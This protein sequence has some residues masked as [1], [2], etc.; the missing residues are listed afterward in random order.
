MGAA[1]I[2]KFGFSLGHQQRRLI[3][4]DRRRYPGIEPLPCDLQPFASRFDRTFRKRDPVFGSAD[5]DISRRHLRDQRQTKRAFSLDGA[6]IARPRCIGK[7]AQPAPEIHLVG[8]NRNPDIEAVVGRGVLAARVVLAAAQ[9]RKRRARAHRRRCPGHLWQ[10]LAVLDPVARP[11][12]CDPGHRLGEIAVVGQRRGDIGPQPGI[13]KKILPAKLSSE[14][15][16]G[17]GGRP[18]LRP[19]RRDRRHW[20]AVAWRHVA[21]GE[22]GCSRQQHQLTHRMAFR[23]PLRRPLLV[24]LQLHDRYCG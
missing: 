20:L 7:V 8:R 22:R 10:T 21:S 5:A 23:L 12:L 11:G 17:G 15:G 4:V 3:I 13:G 19:L 6:E 16:S 2:G 9:Y 18:R 24:R 14:G 1:Q